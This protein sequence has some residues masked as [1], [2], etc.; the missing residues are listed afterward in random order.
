M[1][2]PYNDYFD[3]LTNKIFRTQEDKALYN[4]LSMVLFTTKFVYILPMDENRN[5]DGVSL[6]EEYFSETGRSVEYELMNGRASVLEVLVTLARYCDRVMCISFDDFTW[7][8]YSLMLKNL[9]IDKFTDWKITNDPYSLN[10]IAARLNIFLMR[11]YE[12]DGDGG[13]I[14]IVKNPPE[15]MRIIDIATQMGWYLR[16][17]DDEQDKERE[18]KD[19]EI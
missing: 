10:E 17:Y 18:K 14:F 8:W 11:L 7:Y 9:K 3:W 15:D 12:R 13:N 16:E 1:D 4:S 5:I 6:R 19:Y 2:A